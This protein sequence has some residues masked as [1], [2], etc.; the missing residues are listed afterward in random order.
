[1]ASYLTALLNTTILSRIRRNHG[2]EHA[3][4]HVLAKQVSGIALAGHSDSG[5]FWLIGDVSTEQVSAAVNEALQ[6]LRAGESQ[7]AIHPNCGTNFVTSGVAT[8][9]AGAFA[10]LGAGP[11]GRD[12]LERLPLAAMLATLALIVSK[13]LG[14]RIQQRITTS[15][16]P[17]NLEILEIIPSRR[18]RLTAHRIVTRG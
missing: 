3:T 13:P 11:R 5:G 4:I 17:G 7:L 12:K 10:M 15:G 6:R 2:L 14:F 9:I 1:M 18:G 8:G 16:I